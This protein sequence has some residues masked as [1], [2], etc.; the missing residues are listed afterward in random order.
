MKPMKILQAPQ[1]D[2]IA[3]SIRN[4]R[5]TALRERLAR[6]GLDRRADGSWAGVASR[7]LIKLQGAGWGS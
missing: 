7:I 3:D 6:R 1:E 5:D 2:A 4:V